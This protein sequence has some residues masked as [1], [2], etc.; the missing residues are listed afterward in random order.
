[1]QD[2][3]L[4]QHL[5]MQASRLDTFSKVRE[6]VQDIARAREAAGGVPPIQIGAVQVKVKKGKDVKGKGKGE[7]MQAK[8]LAENIQHKQCFHCRNKFHVKSDCR[9]RQRHKKK[10]K[11]LGKP[12]VDRKQTAAV[13]DDEMIT[14]AVV[15]GMF[16]MA[17]SSHDY[18]FAVM[19]KSRLGNHTVRWQRVFVLL[20]I[21]FLL[22]P[23]SALQEND[24][25]WI[26]VGSGLAVTA[27]PPTH[28][29]EAPI[30]P[31]AGK[32]ADRCRHEPQGWTHWYEASRLSTRQPKD[33][34]DQVGRRD[35]PVPDCVSQ[36]VDDARQ[37]S[38]LRGGALVYGT[39]EREED[40]VVGT[41]QRLMA[42]SEDLER[43]R[44]QLVAVRH[45][46]VS[47]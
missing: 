43:W 11:G 5:M 23:M 30:I 21:F 37:Y 1:M 15:E 13:T 18:L 35:S 26:L 28:S 42:E 31:L 22:E 47:R 46:M 41:R 45:G 36:T 19:E 7:L 14:G 29:Q 16:N 38:G 33:K 8:M 10:A 20:I 6:E 12:F 44:G 34:D 25:S 2:D 27:C 17:S 24:V 9:I 40:G 39:E 3:T 4:R 32:S